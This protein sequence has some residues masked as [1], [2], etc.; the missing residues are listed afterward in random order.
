ML[1]DHSRLLGRSGELMPAAAGMMMCN[2]L[3]AI[4]GK[5]IVIPLIMAASLRRRWNANRA[6]SRMRQS[7]RPQHEDEH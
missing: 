2:A 4:R 1:R 3:L 5:L 6:L 7:A